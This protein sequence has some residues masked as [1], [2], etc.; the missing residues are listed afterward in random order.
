[1][2]A[3]IKNGDIIEIDIE[4]GDLNL[5]VSKEVLKQRRENLSIKESHVTGYLKKYRK[6]VSSASHG[7][8]CL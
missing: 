1:M 3:L 6:I 4:N 7:A 5:E 2:I 8:V